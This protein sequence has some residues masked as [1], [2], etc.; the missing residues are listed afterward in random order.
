MS[1]EEEYENQQSWRTARDK[2]TFIVCE[3][4]E[5]MPGAEDVRFVRAK[6]VD[7]DYRM[8]GDINFFLYPDE[9]EEDTLQNGLIGEVDVMIADNKH[10]G[11]GFG[12]ASVRALL[13]YLQ[14][15]LAEILTEHTT[16]DTSASQG[17]AKLTGL[18]AKIKQDNAGSRALFQKLGFRQRGE[19]NYFGEVTMVMDWGEAER[20]VEEWAEGYREVVYGGLDDELREG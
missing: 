14:R 12:G 9:E 1:L 20:R 13:T 11:Q 2:L 15:H 5:S 19:V 6:D 4:L 16:G 17:G 18:M 7:A 3:P 8:R 10:R